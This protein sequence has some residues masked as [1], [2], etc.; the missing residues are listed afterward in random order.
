MRKLPVPLSQSELLVKAEELARKVRA[1]A[2]I[3][4]EKKAANSDFKTRLEEL[5]MAINE[6]SEIVATKS[7]QRQVECALYENYGSATME[8]VRVDTGEL[9]ETRPMTE[10]ERQAHLF[11]PRDE[12][13]ADAVVVDAIDRL[14]RA[15][16]SAS[17][18]TL[19][20][21]GREPVTLKGKGEEEPAQ[22]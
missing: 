2:D 8:L 15:V 21:P 13:R 18:I 12:Q 11:T 20:A 3:E 5:D 9:I 7:E 22:S 1:A 19:S 17:E 10:A 4:D 14:R 6:L 16:P